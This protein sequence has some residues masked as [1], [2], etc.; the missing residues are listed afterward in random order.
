MSKSE[1]KYLLLDTSYL[2]KAGFDHPDFRNLLRLSK[3][4]KLKIF[5]PHIVW[6]ERRTQ[7]LEGA[8]ANMR[9]LSKAFEKLTEQSVRNI[10]FGGLTPP[11]LIIW[12]EGEID[13]NS[14]TVMTAFAAENKVE[15]VPLAPDHAD[16]AWQRFFRV[17]LPFNTDQPRE[18]RRKDIP[19]SWI[20]ETAID[21]ARAHPDLVALCGDGNL[22]TALTAIPVRVYG[23]ARQILDEIEISQIS[24]LVHL[25]KEIQDGVPIQ[26]RDRDVGET[27]TLEAM[28][29]G[30][31]DQFQKLDA[32]ILGYVSYLGTLSKD[33]LFELLSQEGISPEMARN[34]ADRLA[35]SGIIVDTGNHYISG[36][37]KTRDLVGPLAEPDIIRLLDQD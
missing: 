20:L 26:K 21:L 25:P 12:T 34:A 33:Q 17:E 7:L 8:Y 32:K 14:K 10:L 16:R 3:A 15:I 11:T 6:E 13:T 24:E 9:S 29:A 18:Q 23:E 35:L 36:N 37:K 22:A 4:G 5:I 31:Q 2:R 1:I 27:S 28:L 19:D 30:V